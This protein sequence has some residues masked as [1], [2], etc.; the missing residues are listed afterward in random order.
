MPGNSTTVSG[1]TVVGRRSPYHVSGGGGGG[2]GIGGTGGPNQNDFPADP[3]GEETAP[4]PAE[5]DAEEKRARDCAALALDAYLDQEEPFRKNNREFFSVAFAKDRD[6]KTHT[7]IM[8][9]GRYGN[10]PDNPIGTSIEQHDIEQAVA[11]L[12]TRLSDVRGFNH[13]H[14]SQFYCS[15]SNRFAVNQLRIRS[16]GTHIHQTMTGTPRSGS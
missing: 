1:I 12:G 2:G 3:G 10:D 15:P 16:R 7:P 9:T 4:T 14:P 6:I 11:G 5:A 8:G 13:N